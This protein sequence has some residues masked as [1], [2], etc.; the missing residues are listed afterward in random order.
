MA[1]IDGEWNCVTRTPMG[2]Q[3]SVLTVRSSGNSFTGSNVGPL[4]GVDIAD[5]VIDGDTLTW[6]MELTSPF[7][8]KLAGRATVNG[9]TLQGTVDAGAM[10]AMPLSG[11]RKS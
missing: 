10:G 3:E 11:T 7:P 9:D 4:G 1:K 8:M 5:G 6:T 2:E